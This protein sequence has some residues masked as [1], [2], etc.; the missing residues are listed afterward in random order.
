[1]NPENIQVT[2]E[3]SPKKPAQGRAGAVLLSH[4]GDLSRGLRAEEILGAIGGPGAQPRGQSSG[5]SMMQSHQRLASL[6]PALA[7][8][9][10]PALSP[11][12]HFNIIALQA[13]P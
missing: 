7:S 11:L 4:P 8:R 12:V 1:M 10:K 2:E 3:R 5:P 6:R 13:V 9:L